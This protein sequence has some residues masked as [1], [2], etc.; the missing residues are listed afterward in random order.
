MSTCVNIFTA[1]LHS[2]YGYVFDHIVPLE[3]FSPLSTAPL[4]RFS[5][6]SILRPV[7]VGATIQ[8]EVSDLISWADAAACAFIHT[9]LSHHILRCN[10][11]ATL[12]VQRSAVNHPTPANSLTMTQTPI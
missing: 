3:L 2:I 6:I 1:M 9:M 4:D 8:S 7:V 5:L 10:E 12:G 11:V